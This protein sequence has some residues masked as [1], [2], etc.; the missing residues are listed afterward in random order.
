MTTYE[1][2]SVVVENASKCDFVTDVLLYCC[3]YFC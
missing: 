3:L 1:Y 2:C